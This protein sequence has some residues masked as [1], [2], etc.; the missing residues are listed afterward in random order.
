MQLK[1]KFIGYSPRLHHIKEYK[2]F[3]IPIS[4]PSPL[5]PFLHSI[6]SSYEKKSIEPKVLSVSSAVI[7]IIP[8]AGQP[9]LVL[10][11]ISSALLSS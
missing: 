9:S 3:F 7:F 11:Q 2:T 4:P 1:T 10:I 6:L 5:S 8:S